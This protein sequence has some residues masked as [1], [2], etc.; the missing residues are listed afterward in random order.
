MRF[1]GI[2]GHPYVVERAEDLGFTLNLTNVLTTNVPSDGLFGFVDN[3]P[4]GP[5]AYYRLKYNP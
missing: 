4:L 3:S 5:Q 2:P 1:A